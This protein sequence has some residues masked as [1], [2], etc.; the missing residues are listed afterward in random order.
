MR[1]VPIKTAQNE[2][3]ALF[4]QSQSETVRVMHD[5]EPVGV[6]VDFE[7]YQDMQALFYLATNTGRWNKIIN[8]HDRIQNGD[9]SDAKELNLTPK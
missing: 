3:L 2:L 1:D 4:K 7:D 9:L 5:G 6:L 8:A